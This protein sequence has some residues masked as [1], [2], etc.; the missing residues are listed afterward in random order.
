M[1]L[2]AFPGCCTAHVLT[3]FGGTPTASIVPDKTYTDETMFAD[4]AE[5]LEESHRA[6]MALVFAATTT[7]QEMANRVLPRIGFIKIDESAKDAHADFALIGWVFRL[8]LADAVRPLK[9]P[10]NPF[11]KG[12]KVEDKA[13]QFG[14]EEPDIRANP[15][16]EIV[17]PAPADAQR[18]EMRRM[19]NAGAFGAPQVNPAPPRAPRARRPENRV[20]VDEVAQ[21]DGYGDLTEPLVEG[22]IWADF[23]PGP[24]RPWMNIVTDAHTGQQLSPEERFRIRPGSVRGNRFWYEIHP[25]D[26]GRVD[27]VAIGRNAQVAIRLFGREEPSG[28]IQ[29]RQD[30]DW[31]QRRRISNVT[32]THF[33]LA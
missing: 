19:F 24:G 9:V 3:G 15:V 8:N 26:Q 5:K 13:L 29:R 16:P 28:L 25:N 10:A 18:D 21:A 4:I 17:M 20:I 12:A 31:E 32:I 2:R 11:K 6:R 27:M 14:D 23:I 1:Q 22:Q 33:C 7:Q 30:W